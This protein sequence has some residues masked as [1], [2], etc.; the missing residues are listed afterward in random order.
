MI[1]LAPSA[2]GKSFYVRN[3]SDTFDDFI[4]GDGVISTLLGWPKDPFWYLEEGADV[5][6]EKHN[7][8]LA[9]WIKDNPTHIVFFNGDLRSIVEHVGACVLIP[10]ATHKEYI[11][12][13]KE[14]R[15][16]P[17]VN[18]TN[19]MANRV[20]IREFANQNKIPIFESFDKAVTHILTK[21]RG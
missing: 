12:A 5:I 18:E 6:R 4:D 2:S 21:S 7:Q 1:I 19:I 13:R 15:D 10:E 20:N 14:G 3:T 8:I 17:F 16:N 11:K 9:K